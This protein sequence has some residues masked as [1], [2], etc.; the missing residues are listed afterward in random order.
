MERPW[1]LFT[2]KKFCIGGGGEREGRLKS[3]LRSLV[4]ARAA[5]GRLATWATHCAKEQSA[6][7]KF[8]EMSEGG[9]EEL[10]VPV[11]RIALLIKVVGDALAPRGRATGH[12]R[13][14]EMS[15]F[16][17][18][19]RMLVET[20]CISLWLRKFEVDECTRV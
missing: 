18:H 5:G 10:G 7:L 19:G 2:M 15:L 8:V 6:E 16:G 1:G 3:L 14:S 12:T 20:G 4:P 13:A 17:R 11:V 9:N